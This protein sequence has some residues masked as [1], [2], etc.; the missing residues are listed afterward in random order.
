MIS[1]KGGLFHALLLCVFAAT[2]QA[3]ADT[4]NFDSRTLLQQDHIKSIKNQKMRLQLKQGAELLDLQEKQRQKIVDGLDFLSFKF[5]RFCRLPIQTAAADIDPHRS[6]FV[7]DRAT[8]DGA[9]FSLNRTMGQLASQVSAVVP[10]TTATS[11]FR[12]LWD[13]QNPAP[14][15]VGGSPHCTDNAGTVNG[16]PNQCRPA[17]GEGAEAQGTDVQVQARMDA[18]RPLSL[19]NRMDLAH[20]G[21]RNCGEFRIIYGKPESSIQRN[22]VIFEAVLPNPKPG[23]REGCLQVA[24][25]WKSLSTISDPAVRA[26]RLSEFYYN[27]LPGFRPVVHVDHYS[28]KGTS[29]GY[30]SS[31]GGQI[32]T[33]QFLAFPWMLKEFKTVIDCGSRPCKFDL[34]PVAVKVNPYG[35]LWNEDIANAAGPF[36]ARAAAFESQVLLQAGA[37]SNAGLMKIGYSVDA[38]FDASQSFSMPNGPTFI[39][40]YRGQ[41]NAAAANTFR[42]NLDAAAGTHGLT[43]EQLVNRATTQSCG[44]CH[45]PG[46][47]G[48]TAPNSIGSVTTP[49]GGTTTSWPDVAPNAFVHVN[50]PVT[51]PPELASPIF[52]TGAGQQ[53]STALLDFFLPD[54][55]NFLL[56]QLNEK[57]CFCQPRRV[58]L[59]QFKPK[60]VED[61]KKS[62]DAKFAAQIDK[63]NRDLAKTRDA[64][65][66]APIEAKLAGLTAK[67][68]QEM[69]A[70]LAKLGIDSPEANIRPQAFNLKAARLA[71]GDLRK[72][73]QLRQIEVNNLIKQ[74]PP[75]RTVTGS[76]SVH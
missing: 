55:K 52:G 28:I 38:V 76:F 53:L 4:L 36:Q 56:A 16:Y 23:C 39:D 63:L 64:A 17:P 25:F 27:G 8:L 26:K 68:D 42:T 67:R 19:V 41:V 15:V 71:R 57:R 72:E 21:W 2:A 6:L 45:M 46:N 51:N 44:G 33:N 3:A 35:E 62:I 29:S 22:L 7:H 49:T 12:Q 10:G 73:Q 37:L 5:P 47:F 18:Y 70:G 60:Q 65:A 75:R 66:R 69:D 13:T 43:R 48:L 74:Q 24:E 58:T 54:R 61:L 34:V 50:T 30:S 40:D 31:G 9:D 14:G 1:T 59:D 32:R 20:E 11:I